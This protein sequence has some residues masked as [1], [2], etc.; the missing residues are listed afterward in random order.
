MK[1][2]R[3]VESRT[4]TPQ[5]SIAHYR[6]ASKLG[7]GGMGEVWQA[8]DTKLNRDVA[9]KVLPQ[10]VAADSDRLARFTREAQVLASL[11]HPNIASI[12][13]VE[14]RAL[15]LELVEGPTLAERI[16]AGPLPIDEALPI[17]AQIAE[18]L[19]YA[20]ERGIVHRDL[21]PANVKLTLDGRVKVLD[22]GLAKA[23]APEPPS[24]DVKSSPTLTMRATMAGVIIGTA[25]YMSPEQAKGRVVDRRADIWAFGVVLYEM[26]TGAP[27]FAADNIADTFAAIVTRDPDW[28]AL[29][30]DTPPAVRRLLRRCLLRDLKRRLPDIGVARLEM[31]EPAEAAPS[32]V[33]APKATYL[34]WVVSCFAIAAA[35]LFASLYFFR[36]PPAVRA[37]TF[38]IAA[39]QKEH[40]HN[41]RLSPDG[42][43]MVF[44]IDTASDNAARTYLGLRSIDS[45]EI[46]RL[47]GT[48][49]ATL[50]FWSPDSHWIAYVQGG[51]LRRQEP[52]G[53]PLAICDLPGS[54]G[55]GDWGK[56][57]VIIFPSETAP[58]RVA[59]SG[60]T[61]A[62][63]P[64][65]PGE[66]RGSLRFLPDGKRYLY[67][68]LAPVEGGEPVALRIGSLDSPE[69]T[70]LLDGA[71][72]GAVAVAPDDPRHSHLVYLRD[73]TVVAQAFD[74]ISG[75][76]SGEPLAVQQRKGAPWEI[77]TSASET[78]ALAF[79][80]HEGGDP[81]IGWRSTEA[82]VDV[83]PN[84][85]YRDVALSPDGARAVVTIRSAKSADLWLMRLD[86]QEQS[87]FTL[88]PG[89]TGHPVWSP[90]GKWIAYAASRGASNFIYRKA[91]DGSGAAEVLLESSQP[92]F[93]CDWS[94]DGRFLL[95]SVTDPASKSDLWLLPLTGDRTARIYLRTPRRETLGQIS[96]DGRFLAYQS[97]ESGRYEIYVSTFPDPAG[98][99]WQISQDG[100]RTPRWRRDGRQLFFL[101]A[102]RRMRVVDVRTQPGWLNGIP[103]SLMGLPTFS[104][105]LRFDYDIARDGRILGI[106]DGRHQGPFLVVQNWLSKGKE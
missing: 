9:I 69:S 53:A 11:N 81:R 86:R 16:A 48:E 106:S 47:P 72:D 14:E 59:P 76:L 92:A 33:A 38:L 34:P 52:G 102:T 61:P 95:Y 37:T 79:L 46:E 100:G 35:L 30:K 13:G 75:R 60:G 70:L 43:H 91:A 90:D 39:P 51:K 32:V 26:L 23:L 55:S 103:Q 29:P 98:G 62:P 80:E 94:R 31:D 44:E 78:G 66:S 36:R 63:L 57:G 96:P 54:V 4:M 104:R 17:A 65:K 68:D 87:R 83:A 67:E 45:A 3:C 58:F 15:I 105:E 93:P 84:A 12:Y 97:D 101:A 99:R 1:V 25:G 88:E 28:S 18:A 77:S 74:A 82:V 64:V 42:R 73:G 6:V 21:K 71:G 24:G 19:E 2:V 10:S 20:H 85:P 49:G 89:T 41:G 27:L 5:L 40:F 8:T 50:P 22:F 7:E 56:S